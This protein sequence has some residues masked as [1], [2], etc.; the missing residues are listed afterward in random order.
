VARLTARFV[1]RRQTIEVEQMTDGRFWIELVLAM[2][3]P[4]A[5]VAIITNRIMTKK[6]LSVRSIQFL[7]LAMLAPIVGVL[8][9]EGILERS[10]AGALIGAVLGYLFANI[11]EYDRRRG[12]DAD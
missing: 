4:V 2:A 9:L 1:R 12:G 10:A 5:I 3:V 7:G 11:G 8:A 6:G